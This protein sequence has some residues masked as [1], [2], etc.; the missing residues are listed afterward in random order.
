MSPGTERIYI[1]HVDDEPGFADMVAD[2]LEREDDRF[3]ITTATSASEGMEHLAASDTE[4]HCIVSDYDMPG[5]NGIEFLERVRDEY[6]HLPFVLYTGKG[7][8]AVASDAISAGV[9]DYL[10]KESGTDQYTV[11][12]NRIRNAVEKRRAEQAQERQLEAIETAHEGISILDEGGHF[13]YVNQA[14]GD[15]Y[16]YEP[17]ELVGEHWELIAPEEAVD[18]IREEILPTVEETGFW[19]GRTTGLRADGSTFRE[20]R[21]VA[22]TDRG[23]LVSTVRDVSEQQEH[24]RALAEERTFI[25]QALDVVDDVF[26]FV[27]RDGTVRRWNDELSRVTGYTDEEIAAMDAIDFFPVDERDRI[28]TAIEEALT[29]GNVVVEAEFRTA[30]GKRI[31]YEFTGSRLTDPDGD[32]LGLVG[33][34]RDVSDRKAYEQKLTALHDVADDLTTGTSVEEVC[35]RTIDAAEAVLDFDL[36]VVAI[37]DDEF[38]QVR[39]ASGEMSPDDH[40]GIHVSEGLAGKTYRTGEAFIVD[41]ASSHEVADPQGDFE[42]ALSL[43]VGEH[44]NFQAVAEERNA[45]DEEDLELAELL[46]SHTETVLDRLQREAAL[47]ALHDAATRLESATSETD[48]YEIAVETAEDILEFDFVNVDV[49][50]DDR[51]E[52]QASSAGDSDGYRSVPLDA[53]DNL[54]VRAYQQE[55]TVVENDL[56]NAAVTPADPRLRSALTV[57]IDRFGT[58]QTGSRSVDAFDETDR[59]LAELLVSHTETVLDRLQREAALTA[60]HDAATRLESATSETDV[61]DIVVETAEDILEF[62]LVAVDVEED[63]ALVQRAWTLGGDAE[64]Y[65]EVTPL[66]EDTFATRAFKRQET[67]LVDDLRGYDIT[68]ADPQYRSALTVPIGDVGTFQAVSGDVGAFDETDRELAGLLV[69]HA[70]EALQRLEQERSL[71]EQRDRLRRENER[72][73]QF[74]SIVSHDLRNPLTVANGQLELARTERDSEHL[75]EVATSLERMGTIIEDV[76]AM[77]RGGQAVEESELDPID[78]ADVA[79]K[80]WVTVETADADLEVTTDATVRADRDRLKRVLEN[81]C[82]NAIEHGGRGVTVTIGGR[83][84]GFYVADDGTGIPPEDRDSVFEFGYTTTDDGT[85]FGLAIVKEIVAA[86]GWSIDVIESAGGGA[87]FEIGGVTTTGTAE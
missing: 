68:P 61:Y 86:H 62:D 76:L 34:A 41:E 83:D 38:L 82:R 79:R 18:T 9:T 32:R 77:A 48:V 7:S 19:H 52:L 55:E 80:C 24:Q 53:D 87:R 56:R 63:G 15:L 69:D 45:F 20:D 26:Y 78:L 85:G 8:E 47:T 73:D 70:R 17:E 60:L 6:P 50:V 13:L 43:P 39:A 72:L 57:P 67:L 46:V 71:R 54:G 35:E 12:A 36:S 14:Y 37:E 30:D 25:D 64:G 65:Y 11:L 10:Q 4:I 23:E 44:G 84:D 75:D 74:A 81:L 3:T 59:E 2:F 16:G 5:Q 40:H 31:P 33:I 21:R 22:T 29:T 28:E 49:V 66:D 42:S 27:G 1:L 58:F 51:L